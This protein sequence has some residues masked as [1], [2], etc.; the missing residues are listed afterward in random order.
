[1]LLLVRRSLDE[2]P[3]PGEVLMS[4]LKITTV[5]NSVGVILP[6]EILEHLRVK[7]GD[8]LYA[9]ETKNGIE[10]TPHDPE[11]AKQIRTAEQVMHEDRDALSKLAQ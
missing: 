4:V 11:L 7:S 1:M 5:G 10:L 3:N 9:I 8:T 2:G 6:E